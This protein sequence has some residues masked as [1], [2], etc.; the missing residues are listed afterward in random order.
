MRITLK[1]IYDLEE[2]FQN[3]ASLLAYSLDLVKNGN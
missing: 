1:E 3:E 2:Q